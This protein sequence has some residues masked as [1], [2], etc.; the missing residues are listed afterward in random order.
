MHMQTIRQSTLR[1]TDSAAAYRLWPLMG[2]I[3]LTG[4][5]I[6]SK[7]A[8]NRYRLYFH[9]SNIFVRLS[10]LS[11]V[12]HY[13][14]TF[15]KKRKKNLLKTNILLTKFLGISVFIGHVDDTT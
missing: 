11:T 13:V 4:I 6:P 10:F 5:L 3:K 8:T 14:I 2:L 9:V 12:V 7:S 1:W 15:D